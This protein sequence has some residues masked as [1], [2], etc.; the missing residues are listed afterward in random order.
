MRMLTRTAPAVI[1]AMLFPLLAPVVAHASR[2]TAPPA[3]HKQAVTHKKKAASRKKAALAI[4][5]VNGRTSLGDAYAVGGA[6]P[7]TWNIGTSAI[8]NQ[9]TFDATAGTYTLTSFENTLTSPPTQYV[10]SGG[11]SAEFRFAWG[12]QELTGATP[13]WSCQSGAVRQVNMGGQP[14]LQLDVAVERSGV[15]VTKSYVIYPH[16]SLIRQWTQ[17]TN[18]SSTPQELA[19]IS[20][21]DQQLMGADTT[22]GQVQLK[23]MTGAQAIPNSWQTQTVPL[24]AAYARDFDSWDSAACITDPSK[25]DG[26]A[27]QGIPNACAAGGGYNLN[28]NIYIPWFS[29]WNTA[30]NNGVY[31]GFDYFGHWQAQIGNLNGGDASLSVVIP[32]YDSQ[33]QPGATVTSPKAFTGTYVQNL[34]DMTNR[35]LDWQY[36]YMWDD[37]RPAYFAN[38]RMLGTWSNGAICN[39][40]LTAGTPDF[41]GTLQK[42]FGLVDHMAYIGA[43]TYHRD[44][45]WWNNAGDWQGPDWKITKNYLAKYGMQQLIYYWA[46]L[47]SSQSQVYQQHPDWFSSGII[48]L[49]N[50][51]ALT[52]MENLLVS[53]AQKWGDYQWRN[54][55]GMVADTPGSQQLAQDQG[56]RTAIQYFLD[57]CPGC[58]FQ[59]VNGG[60][61]Y[62]GWDYVRQGSSSSFTDLSGY[63]QHA[64]ASLL[65]PTD[66]LSGIPDAWNP[67]NCNAS[68]NALLQF[69]PDFTGDT[70]NAAALKCMQKLVDTYHYLLHEGV[71]RPVGTPVPPECHGQQQ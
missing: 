41:S 70:N 51:A 18:T 4:R 50:P 54:D 55:A 31:M 22:S 47:A 17:Y 56:L 67:A 21:L 8:E 13:G 68:Y 23:Y 14:A 49:S 71:A 16:E 61:G 2:A 39:F 60:G 45:G 43:G 12:G 44:C 11:A 32:D 30:H 64:A 52:Y 42:V 29:L 28:S 10:Q 35:L 53:N 26:P 46:Y 38:I 62:I 19:Q 58:A 69:N 40:N 48:D 37:T 66:K 36:R 3:T 33:I 1:L 9:L 6:N 34:D 20:F 7:C 15:R 65:F 24:T 27:A 63:D 5:T 57:H 59:S 25:G